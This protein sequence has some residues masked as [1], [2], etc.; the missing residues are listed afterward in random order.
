MLISRWVNELNDSARGREGGKRNISQART[1]RQK[2]MRMRV[3]KSTNFLLI[4]TNIL[5]SPSFGMVTETQ[6][7]V[8][9]DYLSV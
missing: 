3:Q 8:V 4:G 7:T 9:I 6:N 2:G 5:F 1:E